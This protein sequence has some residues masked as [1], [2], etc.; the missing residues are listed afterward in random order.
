M[1]HFFGLSDIKKNT[2]FAI[3]SNDISKDEFEKFEKGLKKEGIST[4]MIQTRKLHNLV[5]E[6][7]ILMMNEWRDIIN[8]SQTDEK[9]KWRHIKGIDRIYKKIMQE[10]A[11]KIPKN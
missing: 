6:G 3:A 10:G 9:E 11:I 1:V 4:Y 2:R 5:T 8:K 7:G